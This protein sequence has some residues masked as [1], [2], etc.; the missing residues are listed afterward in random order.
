M[1][2]DI[3]LSDEMHEFGIF[4]L[5]PF[6]PALRQEFLSVGN[7]AD[8]SIEP[9]IEHLAFRTFNRNRNAPVQVTAHCTRLKTAV[10]PA[11]ALSIDIAS[12]LLVTVENPV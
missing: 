9:D 12:P 1:E 7:I 5:P 3:V 11:L 2:D 4:F 6:L 8:R 10:N